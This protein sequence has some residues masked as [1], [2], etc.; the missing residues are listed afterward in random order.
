[1]TREPPAPVVSW[2]K[3]G[4]E[5]PRV[6]VPSTGTASCSPLAWDPGWASFLAASPGSALVLGPRTHR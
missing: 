4:G 6:L 5:I 1:M 3:K 2:L